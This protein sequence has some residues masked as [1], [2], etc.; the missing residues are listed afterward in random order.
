[1]KLSVVAV[2][3]PAAFVAVPICGT[4]ATTAVACTVA[5]QG[6]AARGTAVW[7]AATRSTARPEDHAWAVATGTI[8]RRAAT[9]MLIAAAGASLPVGLTSFQFP[10]L[11]QFPDRLTMDPTVKSMILRSCRID[12]FLR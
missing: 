3:E 1:M 5:V 12:M 9:I 10:H 11:D 4:D 6:A 7:A 8:V 2:S